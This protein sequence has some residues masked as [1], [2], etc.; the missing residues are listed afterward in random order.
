LIIDVLLYIIEENRVNRGGIK[1]MLKKY[2]RKQSN[3]VI[4][5]A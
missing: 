5:T 4:S 3:F 2:W 1:C